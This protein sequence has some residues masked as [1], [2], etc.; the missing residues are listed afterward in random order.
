[1]QVPF[2]F[3]ESTNEGE[4]LMCHPLINCLVNSNSSALQYLYL[5]VQLGIVYG[6]FDVSFAEAYRPCT[7]IRN[8]RVSS[9]LILLLV[10]VWRGVAGRWLVFRMHVLIRC[11]PTTYDCEIRLSQTN[12][13]ECAKWDFQARGLTSFMISRQ[14]NP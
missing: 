13:G 5:R 1:M 11:N 12:A 10:V 14:Q 7:Y 3:S 8:L 6:R 2:D 9:T 4:K